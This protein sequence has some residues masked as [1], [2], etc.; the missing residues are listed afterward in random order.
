MHFSLPSHLA[1]AALASTAW[2]HGIITIPAPRAVGAASSTACG[3]GVTNLIKA[4]NTL[5]VKGLLEAAATNSAYNAA[6][7]NLRLCKGLQL[8]DNKANVQKFTVGGSGY[9]DLDS[10][11]AYRNGERERGGY[12]NESGD[13]GPLD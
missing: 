3:S 4:D 12:E 1:A 7:C 2:S 6:Q 13:W 9:V 11:S 10:S 8:A 5:H